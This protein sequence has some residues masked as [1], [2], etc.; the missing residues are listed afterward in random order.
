MDERT[1]CYEKLEES[2][3]TINEAIE[4]GTVQWTEEGR[5]EPDFS[6]TVDDW[7]PE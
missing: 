4:A 2:L 1:E 5:E 3:E 6:T 7:L